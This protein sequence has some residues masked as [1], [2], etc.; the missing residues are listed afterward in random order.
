MA[1]TSPSSSTLPKSAA[2]TA[3]KVRCAYRARRS[4]GQCLNSFLARGPKK[5]CSRKHLVK[6]YTER[7]KSNGSAPCRNPLRAVAIERDGGCVR[8]LRPDQIKSEDE[9]QQMGGHEL[10]LYRRAYCKGKL[11]VRIV[12][13]A[14]PRTL[15]NVETLCG[16]HFGMVSDGRFRERV[17]PERYQQIKKTQARQY[18]RLKAMMRKMVRIYRGP[19]KNP[20]DYIDYI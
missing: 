17:G 16:R 5:Y 20:L 9:M 13:A 15:E 8:R 19:P 14:K 12:D 3:Q 6:A 7:R 1:E 2:V 10:D 11:L 18:Y 4:G